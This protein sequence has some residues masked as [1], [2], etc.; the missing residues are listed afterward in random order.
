MTRNPR[1]DF[2]AAQYGPRAA[3]YVESITHSQGADLDQIEALLTGWPQARVLDL[4]CGGGH[5]SLRAAPHVAEVVACDVTPDML[6]AV[7]RTAAARGLDNIQVRE[8][9]AEALPFEA[10][11]FD[12]VLSRFSAHH[13]QDLEAGLREVRRVLRPDGLA[14]LI[15][16]VA[17]EDPMLDTHLQAIE[18]LRDASHVRNFRLAEWVAALSRSRLPAHGLT[19]RRLPLEFAS[20]IARTRPDA[21]R[22]AAIHAIQDT[23]PVAARAYFEVAGD[24]SFTIDTMTVLA[25][26]A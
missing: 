5:V 25:S 18:L 10:A 12:V 23:A 17:P 13:W 16:T 8:G 3:A 4:G 2:V 26:P 21:V 9:A 22:V 14:V 24:G 7:R 6:D 15:D 11:C 1:H 20:W 19:C